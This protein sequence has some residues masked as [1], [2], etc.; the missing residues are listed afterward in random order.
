MKSGAGGALFLLG[1]LMLLGYV[2]LSLYLYVLNLGGGWFLASI[3]IF[4]LAFLYPFVSL[5]Q[6]GVF[7]AGVAALGAVGLAVAMVGTWLA[8]E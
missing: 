5:W 6:L 7:P 8:E 2:L 1:Q 3:I 4:P